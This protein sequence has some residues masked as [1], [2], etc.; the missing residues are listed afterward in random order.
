MSIDPQVLRSESHGDIGS[1]IQRDAGILIDRWCRR[2]IEE[3]PNA[4]RVH[5]EVLRDRLPAFLSAL[6][7][8]L[9]ASDDANGSQHRAPAIEHGE[10]RWESG[11]SLPEVFRDY[12]ILRL[13]IV[14]YLEEALERPLRG[15]EVMAVGLALDEAITVSVGMYVSNREQHVRQVERQRSEQ[16]SL[17]EEQRR[18]WEQI[19][20]HAAWGV[21]IMHPADHTLQS[22]NPALADMHGYSVEELAGKRLGDLL[23]PEDRAG[24]AEQL[25]AADAHGHHSYQAVHR[26]KDGTHFPA[27]TDVVAIKDQAGHVLYRAVNCRDISQHKR[28]EESLRLHAEALQ[29]ADSR[30]DEFL[31]MLAHE[32]RNSLAPLLHS[33]EVL[34]LV[35]T[36]EPA[37]V[38][39]KDVLERQVRQMVRLVDDLLDL[40]RI[41]RGKVELRKERHALATIVAQAVETSGP[42]LDASQHQLSVNLPTE[43]LWL[44]ADQ[45]RLVQVFANLLNNA[46]KYT[47][48]GGQ[49]VLTAERQGN[50]AVI[51]VRDTGAGIPPYMLHR[52]FDLFTQVP[53]AP[54]PGQGGLGVGLAL[55][56]RLVELHGGKVTAH[57]NGPGQGS[58]FVVR[59]PACAEAPEGPSAPVSNGTQTGTARHVLMVE[60][61]SDSRETLEMLLALLGHRVD[62]AEDGPQGVAKAVAVRPQVALIDIGLPGMDG[63]EVARQ[64]RAAL[65][66]AIFLIALTGYGQIEDRR[67]ASEAGFNAHLVKPVDMQALATL[68]DQLPV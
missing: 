53:R 46:A 31:A 6:G 23:A 41:S 21:A 26:R 11:W 28:L 50:E 44:E 42:V 40:S 36:P 45:A 27:L 2:A 51:R 57:S 5:G 64:V 62:T 60:D 4:A 19:F 24:L 39:V 3:Q 17:A 47:D 61:H 43:P 59:L 29:Q 13:V 35:S 38:Q 33:A 49:I 15:R 67:R 14:E 10:Q 54:G 63:Y 58:E 30:K 65:G 25:G 8:S 37:I 18:R 1:V 52:I 22:L 12:Q 9:A 20:R 56:R 66:D 7:Q 55:V 34:R 48:T 16:E 32:L 68:L